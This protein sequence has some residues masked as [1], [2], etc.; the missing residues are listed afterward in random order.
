MHMTDFILSEVIMGEEISFIFFILCYNESHSLFCRTRSKIENF[1]FIFSPSDNKTQ[2]LRPFIM[3]LVK[4]CNFIIKA[5]LFLV[6]LLVP[7]FFQCYT[8]RCWEINTMVL[9]QALIEILAIVWLLKLILSGVRPVLSGAKLKAVL[10]GLI[11]LGVLILATIFSASPQY[12]FLGS[13][14]RRMGLVTWLHLFA[15]F[16][17]IVLEDWRPRDIKLILGGILGSMVG[18]GAFS[19]FQFLGFDIVTWQWN[20]T[21]ASIFYR[22]IF[23]SFGQPNFLASWLLLVIP[24]GAFCFFYFKKFYV[25]VFVGLLT[26]WSLVVLVLTQSRGAWLGF[27]AEI[28][29][30]IGCYLFIKRKKKL[31]W[32]LAA[33]LAILFII[34]VCLNLF[35]AP[36]SPSSMAK[37]NIDHPLLYRLDTLIFV[38]TAVTVH[39]RL[40]TWRVALQ[41][42][43]QRPI[44]GYGPDVFLFEA[45]KHYRPTWA[46]YEAINT[47]PDRAHND[48]LDEALTAGLLGLLAYLIF[49]VYIFYRALRFIRSNFS[50]ANSWAKLVLVLLV[51]LFGYLASMQFSFHDIQTVIYF[52]LYLALIIILSCPTNNLG[53]RKNIFSPLFKKITAILIVMIGLLLIYFFNLRVFLADLYYRRAF[54]QFNSQQLEKGLDNFARVFA[55]QPEQPYYREG[56]AFNLNNFMTSDMPAATKIRLVDLVIGALND[57]SPAT[58]SFPARLYLARFYGLKAGLSQTPEDF[59]R[60]EQVFLDFSNWSPQMAIIYGDWCQLKIYE[61]DWSAAL[62]KCNEAINLY[63]E[64]EDSRLDKRLRQEIASEMITVYDKLGQVYMAQHNYEQA[65]NTYW[66][67]LHLNPSQYQYY[68][69]I[70]DVYYLRRDLDSAIKYNLKGYTR[71]PKDYRW[72]WAIALLYYEKDNLKLAREY[73]GQALKLNPDNQNI[74]LFLEKIK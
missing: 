10:L 23:A 11:F 46:V 72:P 33:I 42:I 28:I 65:L 6:I 5:C 55:L 59:K 30:L 24:V 19:F 35:V 20:A 3:K 53:W 67:I 25:R 29:F 48:F 8:N 34:Y 64:L 17:I 38:K 63:P 58:R 16:L 69:K 21:D 12:S 13:Y 14:E 57:T 54:I 31:L 1:N 39:T 49:I 36:P 15:F 41:V 45:M 9:F 61:Q 73:G 70:A 52:W 32:M 27:L 51:G 7:V 47:F 43:A 37:D 22:R 18:V 2:G 68:K 26:I 66:I 4:I 40:L 71:S 44:L 56:L 50:V 74:K 60:A 62:T